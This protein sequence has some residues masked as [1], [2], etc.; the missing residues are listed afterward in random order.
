MNMRMRMQFSLDGVSAEG[1]RS[2]RIVWSR[3]TSAPTP[4]FLPYTRAGAVP[5]LTADVAASVLSSRQDRLALLPLPTLYVPQ[6]L[7]I[8][9]CVVSALFSNVPLLGLRH[10]GC[11]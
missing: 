8:I 10:L 5:H 9:L 4:L 2:G 3:Q 6:A 11:L 7:Y 1:V